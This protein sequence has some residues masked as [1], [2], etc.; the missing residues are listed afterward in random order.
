VE[1]A[2]KFRTGNKFIL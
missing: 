1:H 2:M